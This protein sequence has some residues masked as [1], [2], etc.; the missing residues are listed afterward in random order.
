MPA[1]LDKKT[2][3]IVVSNAGVYMCEP[4]GVSKFSYPSLH[5]PSISF[6]T[7]FHFSSLTYFVC[8]CGFYL[9][10]TSWIISPQLRIWRAENISLTYFYAWAFASRFMWCRHPALSS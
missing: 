4:L 9:K 6:F 7:L 1:N 10:F 2:K 8:F 3:L 5:F